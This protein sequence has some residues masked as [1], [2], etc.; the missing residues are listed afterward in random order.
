MFEIRRATRDDAQIAFDIRRL[1][2]RAQC[3]GPYSQ[4]DML[5]WTR[6]SLNEWFTDLVQ[7]H[8]QLVCAQGRVV[9]TGMLDVE[10]G[11]IG[12]IFVHPEFMGRGIGRLLIEHLEGLALEANLAQI[13]LD[14]TLNAVAFYRACGFVGEQRSIYQSPSGL[15][16]ACVPM[17]KVL[18]QS[19]RP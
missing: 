7:Q 6:G 2:I 4:Q 8:F 9:A 12:A 13:K 15:Q 14:A 16:L 19:V 11:E 1:A 18:G 10:E 17:L 5:A 3:I